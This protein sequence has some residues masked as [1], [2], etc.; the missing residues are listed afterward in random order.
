MQKIKRTL[1]FLGTAAQ[2]VFSCSGM[3]AFA[4]EFLFQHQKKARVN[5][6]RLSSLFPFLYFIYISPSTPGSQVLIAGI[7]VTSSSAMMI[8]T[9]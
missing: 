6:F 8:A 4:A 7:K 1:C 5:L 3:T 9:K 2:L